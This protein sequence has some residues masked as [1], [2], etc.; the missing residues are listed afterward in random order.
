[1][2][3]LFAILACVLLAASR[4]SGQPPGPPPIFHVVSK[5][6]PDK[7]LI[8]LVRYEPVTEQVAVKV[9]VNINGQIVEETRSEKRVVYTTVQ[10]SMDIA[11]ARVITPDGKQMPIDEVWKRLKANTVVVLSGDGNTPAQPYLRALSSETLVIIPGP[12]KK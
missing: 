8:F 2:K 6:I 4:S 11:N 12:M 5:T 3:R 10:Y 1:M 9:L 7:G